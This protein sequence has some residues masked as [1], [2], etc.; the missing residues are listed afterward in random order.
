[1]AKYS[2]QNPLNNCAD[3]IHPNCLLHSVN[4][5]MSNYAAKFEHS[6][7]IIDVANRSRILVSAEIPRNSA[8]KVI[9]CQQ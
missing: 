8:L 9:Y 4:I 7:S 6:I 5:P 2:S 1:M 3:E